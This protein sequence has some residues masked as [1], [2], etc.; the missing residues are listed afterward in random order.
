MQTHIILQNVATF[1]VDWKNMYQPD[2]YRLVLLVSEANNQRLLAASQEK[3]FHRIIQTDNFSLENLT[4][5]TRQVLRELEIADLSQVKIMT[6][7]E[8]SLGVTAKLR[9]E[10]GIEGDRFEQLRI[11]I[12]KIEMK[13]ALAGKGIRIPK[14][15]SFD[16]EQYKNDS[17]AYANLVEKRLGFPVFVKPI[18]ESGS[19]GAQ[20]IE[21]RDALIEWCNAHQDDDY[22]EVDE[23]IDG[24]LYHCDSIIKDGEILFTQVSEYAH[25]CFDYISGEI[26]ASI[27][28]P[29]ETE[30][31]QQL[32]EFAAKVIPA[33]PAMPRSTVTHLEVFKNQDG[34]LIFLE[35]AAR[36]PAAMVPYTYAKFLGVNIEEA[37]FRLQMGTFSE[38]N[39]KRGP[40]CAWVYFPHQEGVVV[41]LHKPSMHSEHEISWRVKVGDQLQNP[42][43]I[44]DTACTVMLW[45][46]D[47]TKLKKDFDYLDK[48]FR[49]YSVA[50]SKPVVLDPL[51]S[52]LWC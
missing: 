41:E 46:D 31:F 20:K 8:Y 25:P 40:Y 34:E 32:S 35:I 3:Y 1:R 21:S 51:A 6:H 28:L 43:D 14:H 9:E 11:F 16:A 39:F 29:P 5:L 10:I 4:K 44:R 48:S 37:H 12:D 50:K 47:F 19:V 49:P 13:R 23:F 18:N 15:F 33:I 45:N 22:F 24:K 52:S 17:E 30:D 7:D 26:C 36:A 2:H 38:M 42:Q 27:T